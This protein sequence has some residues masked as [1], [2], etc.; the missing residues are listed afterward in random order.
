MVL[1]KW[2][3]QVASRNIAIV[4]QLK[5]ISYYI[6]STVAERICNCLGLMIWCWTHVKFLSISNYIKYFVDYI[7]TA[8]VLH[9]L[10]SA[11]CKGKSSYVDW[12]SLT[13]PW[14]KK[15]HEIQNCR[16]TAHLKIYIFVLCMYACSLV[17]TPHE[18]IY[19]YSPGCR[20]ILSV[21]T[22]CVGGVVILHSLHN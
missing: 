5:M 14:L 1:E 6:K 22:V 21:C 19:C 11:N 12:L 3:W 15:N 10:C 9:S 16:C 13:F 4:I 8:H 18:D 7:S 20:I 2:E 17:I